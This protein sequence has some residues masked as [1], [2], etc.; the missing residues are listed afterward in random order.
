[1]VTLFVTILHPDAQMHLN[2]CNH[3]ATILC[4]GCSLVALCA[5]IATMPCAHVQ[6]RGNQ[7][8]LQFGC[9]IVWLQFS[10]LGHVTLDPQRFNR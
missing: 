4:H 5:H 6:S 3:H 10:K 7:P 2:Y 8:W 1:M 9:K